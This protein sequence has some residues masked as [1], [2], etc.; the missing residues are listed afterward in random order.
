MIK[1]S[2]DA[3]FDEYHCLADVLKETP[4]IGATDLNQ[5]TA[6]VTEPSLD[7]M[8]EDANP[9]TIV[10]GSVNQLLED[11][12]VAEKPTEPGMDQRE[13]DQ[14]QTEQD[15]DQRESNTNQEP[16]PRRSLRGRIQT[17]EWKAWTAKFELDEHYEPSCF[18]DAITC[19]EADKWRGLIQEEYDALME[20][21]TWEIIPCPPDR[22]PIK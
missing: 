10:K 20:N 1:I 18:N 11:S 14:D 16:T 12:I 13:P 4:S 9:P 3:T 6:P 19:P 17:K 21:D 15:V 5:I 22:K 7:L 2:R 8:K